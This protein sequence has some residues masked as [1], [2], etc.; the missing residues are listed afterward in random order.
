AGP[1]VIAECGDSRRQIAYSGET[2]NGTARLQAHC[3]EAGR[4]RLVSG[5]LLRLLPSQPDLAIEPLGSTQLRGRAA[6]IDIFAVA[7]RATS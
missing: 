3:K 5:E 2:V 4:P 7:R 6:S 1:V